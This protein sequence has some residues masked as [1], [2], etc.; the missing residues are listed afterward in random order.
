VKIKRIRISG[1]KSIADLSLEQVTPYSIF[2]GANGAGKSN[3]ADALAFVGA[4]IESG[5]TKAIRQFNGFASIHCYKSRRPKNC[6]FE[7]EIEVEIDNKNIF[8]TLKVYS[9]DTQPA[10][11]ECLYLGDKKNIVMQREKGK[12]ATTHSQLSGEHELP[13]PED[14]SAL[15]FIRQFPIYDY[16][17][18]IKVFRFDPLGAKEPD[19]SSSD[20]SGLNSHGHNVATMLATL[21]KDEEFRTQIMDWMTLI[22]PSMEKVTTEQ[23][24]LDNK[25]FIKFKEE[26]TKAQFPAS[27]ISDGT[28]YALCIMTAVLSRSKSKGLTIIEEPERGIHPQA[29]GELVQL[30]RR[31]ATLEHPVFVTSHSESV[32][33]ASKP[34]ELWLVNKEDGKTHAKNAAQNCGDLGDL[35]LDK[36]WLMNFFDGGLPW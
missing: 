5:A 19:A 13:I 25:T 14:W 3:L 34:E 30:M 10:L 24:R 26:G 18:N 27:L 11:E 16:L 28:I 9:M 23:Q 36:A 21:E 29:I 2:A 1:F 31:C 32:V 12:S 20:T 4:I 15:V 33:R 22:V 8:Y 35:N 17:T 6:K 7:F